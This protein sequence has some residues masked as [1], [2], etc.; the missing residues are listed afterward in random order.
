VTAPSI[1]RAPCI[2][3][4]GDIIASRDIPRTQRI[5]LQGRFQELIAELNKKY[6]KWLVSRFIITLGDE[7]QGLLSSA[8]PIPD[9]LWDLENTSTGQTFRVGFGF[10]TIDTLVPRYA[11]NVD[12]PALHNARAAIDAAKSEHELGGLFRGFGTLDIILNGFARMLWFHRTRLTARQLRIILLL[13]KGLTQTQ[14]AERLR[15]SRQAVSK[16]VQASGW[17][18]YSQAEQSWRTL[19]QMYVDPMIKGRENGAQ[20]R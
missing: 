2:A 19:L 11:I 5:R 10:G 15:I 12:G 14:I 18:A 16:H 7:F 4:I 1:R 17:D 13:R 20:A 3:V 9:F 8:S 6:S